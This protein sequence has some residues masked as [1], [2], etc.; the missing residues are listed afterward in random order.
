L[1][2]PRIVAVYARNMSVCETV[3]APADFIAFT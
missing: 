3:V 2:G 1:T